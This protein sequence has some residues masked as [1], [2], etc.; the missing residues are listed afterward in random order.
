[1]RRREFIAFVGGTAVAWPLRGRA[2]QAAL[3]VVG[4]VS[5]QSPHSDA[6]NTTAFYKG[7]SEAGYID[8]QNVTVEYHWVEGHYDRLPGVMADLVRRQVA[9][10]ATTGNQAAALAAKAATA[11]I[12]IVFAVGQD[13]V[14]LGLVASLARPGGNATG[15]NDFLGEVDAKRLRLLQDMVPK[16]ARVAVLVNPA[17]VASA[18]VTLQGT[19]EAAAAT[20]VQLQILNATTIAEIDAAFASFARERP[21]ALFVAADSFF[22]SRA[23]QFITLTARD[24]LPAAYHLRDFVIAGGLMSYGVDLAA[25]GHEVG[26]YTGKILRGAKPADL[27]VQQSTKF[28]FAINLQT[29]RAL[30]I[31]VPSGLLSIAD[32][33]IE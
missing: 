30:G 4:V 2:Q 13:P 24:R 19:Q 31:E 3:P 26:V 16:A 12:P 23:V 25:I 20:G 28:N 8:G 21:D 17:N 15:V 33:V 32:E 5:G 6:R 22:S 11:T 18:D 7:L 10:I 9:V 27:P 1:M 29:A 14:K